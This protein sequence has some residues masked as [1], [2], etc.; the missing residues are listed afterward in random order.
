MAQVFLLQLDHAF[1]VFTAQKDH[2]RQQL[3]LALQDLIALQNRQFLYLVKTAH[4]QVS[5]SLTAACPALKDPT[6]YFVIKQNLVQLVSTA[7]RE[8][9]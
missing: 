5:L 4:T 8:L 2:C 7:L 9:V 3:D 6:V 1:V